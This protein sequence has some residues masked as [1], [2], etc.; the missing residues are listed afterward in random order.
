MAYAA[1]EIK[2]INWM[3]ATLRNDVK[4]KAFRSIR[5]SIS[6]NPVAVRETDDL[7][8]MYT[9]HN[10]FLTA[11]DNG[12]LSGQMSVRAWSEKDGCYIDMGW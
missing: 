8:E 2:D 5:F 1:N 12:R 11:R 4:N 6:G 10:I 9:A 7:S 3:G